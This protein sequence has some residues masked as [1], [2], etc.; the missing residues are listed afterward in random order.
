M[1]TKILKRIGLTAGVLLT[2]LM[3]SGAVIYAA[4]PTYTVSVSCD[5]AVSPDEA[6]AAFVD[7]SQW[8]NYFEYDELF[9]PDGELALGT[10]FGYRASEGDMALE[11]IEY[12]PGEVVRFDMQSDTVDAVFSLN[13]EPIEGGTRVTATNEFSSTGILRVMIVLY[14]LSGEVQAYYGNMIENVDRVALE[15]SQ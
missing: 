1:M 5:I 11:V 8:G 13:L 12:A 14:S 3:L 7:F 6:F 4:F 2:L 9:P 10:R 15:K